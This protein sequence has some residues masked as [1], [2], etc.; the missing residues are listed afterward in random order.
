MLAMIFATAD[1]LAT[2]SLRIDA[3]ITAI[4][5]ARA[6]LGYFCTNSAVVPSTFSGWPFQISCVVMAVMP[7]LSK[8][9]R[10]FH[11]SPTHMRAGAPARGGAAGGG[12]GAAGG[13]AA[14]GG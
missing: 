7:I 12:G 9:A 10:A 2:V 4:S 1:R 8:I 6:V 13:G 5:S 3:S 11:G 14:G